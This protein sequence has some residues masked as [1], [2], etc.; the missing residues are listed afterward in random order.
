MERK[1]GKKYMIAA[2]AL[3]ESLPHVTAR[4]AERMTRLNVAF[5][6]V[7][8]GEVSCAHLKNVSSIAELRRHN[9]GIQLVLSVGGWGAGGFS[10][11]AATAPGRRQFA[12]SA[13]RAVAELELDGIDIDWEYP[14]IGVAGIAASPAD[15][16]NYTLLLEETRRALDNIAGRRRLLTIAAGADRYFIDATQM[17][18][19]QEYLDEVQLMTYDMRGGFQTLTGHHACLHDSTGDLF[20][21]SAEGSVKLFIE[22]GVP[23]EK[24][25]MGAAFYS[26]RWKGVPNV[27]RGLFQNA[28]GT[29]E[30]FEHYD[31]LEAEYVNKNGF[32]RYWDEEACAPWLFN[33][34]TFISYEDEESIRCKCE[35]IKMEGLA[36][37]M[38]WEHGCDGTGKLLGAMHE[39]LNA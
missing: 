30:F 14:C 7:R 21:I 39:G 19:A 37:I 18:D 2:Y 32:T 16:R 6:L 27:N 28:A 9:P 22:A 1:S 11:A 38:Y 13:A 31:K 5:G 4:D 20:R 36:G 24:L 10:E 26:R 33:G 15:R 17:R 8:D 12:E 25:V 34:D 29:G 3:D 35:F 23:R